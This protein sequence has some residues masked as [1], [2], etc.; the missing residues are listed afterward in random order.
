[1]VPACGYVGSTITSLILLTFTFIFFA[2]EAAIMALAL[3][4]YLDWPIVWC[5]IASAIVIVPLVP[6][7][8]LISRIADL[9]G[10]VM[11]LSSSLPYVAIAIRDPGPFAPCGLSGYLGKQRV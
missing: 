8:T 3:R 1:M 5:Y 11:V 4:L 7:I 10:A 9:V 2:L 6:G